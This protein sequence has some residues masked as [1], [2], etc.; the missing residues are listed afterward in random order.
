MGLFDDV[1]CGYPL[2]EPKHQHREFQTKD[3]GC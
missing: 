1:T 3:L 2:P